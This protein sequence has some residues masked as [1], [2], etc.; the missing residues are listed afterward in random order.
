MVIWAMA[1]A[2]SSATVSK[3]DSRRQWSSASRIMKLTMTISRMKQSV[4]LIETMICAAL[5]DAATRL[6]ALIMVDPFKEF[7]VHMLKSQ[8][9]TVRYAVR[10]IARS[11]KI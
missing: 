7:L 3:E 1:R 4:Q 9:K 6:E 11:T 10:R 2:Q 8:G 5:E